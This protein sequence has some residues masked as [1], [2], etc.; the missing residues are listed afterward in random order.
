[1]AEQGLPCSAEMLDQLR[2]FALDLYSLNETRNLTRVPREEF[3]LRHV[4]DSLLI[5]ELL[6]EGAS[7][8]DIGTGPG[9]PAW[10]LAWARPDLR[11]TALDS[12]NK[13][14]GFLVRHGLPNLEAVLGR[15]EEWGV[16]ER[17]D[18][19]TGRAVAPLGI[20]MELSAAPCKVGGAVIPMRSVNDLSEIETKDLSVLGVVLEKVERR[21]LPVLDA[22]RL[23]PV[24]RKTSKTPR[25]Y[26]RKWA[27][28]RRKPL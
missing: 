19:V 2:A 10:P 9:F 17:F 26:P 28:I 6:P 25:E 27:D 24:Y 3:W 22:E 18:V 20:Q 5:H 7:I 14:I 12:S 16:R 13:M 11:V 21:T 4:V 15:A 23:F 8:L 1:M